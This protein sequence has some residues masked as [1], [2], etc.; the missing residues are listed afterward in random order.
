M[1]VAIEF[2]GSIATTLAGHVIAGGVV[3]TTFT[4]RFAVAGLTPS[5]A[6]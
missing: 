4:V 1:E 3:S 5:V 2:G 6:E